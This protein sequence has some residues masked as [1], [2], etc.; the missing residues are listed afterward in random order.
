MPT[1]R[2]PYDVTDGTVLHRSFGNAR[3]KLASPDNLSRLEQRYAQGE[4]SAEFLRQ[5]RLG[6]A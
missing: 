4:R 6:V 1:C 5:L 2:K 3:Q